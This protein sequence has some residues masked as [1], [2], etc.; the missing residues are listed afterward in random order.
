MAVAIEAGAR[1]EDPRTS[2]LAERYL[3][4][5]PNGRF[6]RV[7]DQALQRTR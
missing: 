1:R 7:A 6:R 2:T 4:T 5:Y 3:R